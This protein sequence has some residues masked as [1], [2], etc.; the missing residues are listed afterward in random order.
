MSPTF[1]PLLA[2]IKQQTEPDPFE[3]YAPSTSHP[4]SLVEPEA[5]PDAESSNASTVE[6]SLYQ[7]GVFGKFS[8]DEQARIDL[9]AVLTL[10]RRGNTSAAV[11]AAVNVLQTLQEGGWSI[12]TSNH[13]GSPS[14]LVMV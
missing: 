1:E 2:A 8:V 6:E 13:T 10:K 3:Q 7:P 11:K 5:T 9:Q 4:A 12:W 14:R